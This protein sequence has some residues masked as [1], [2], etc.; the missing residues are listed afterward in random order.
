[1]VTMKTIRLSTC[2]DYG[3]ALRVT[4]ALLLLLWMLAVPR[5]TLQ[6]SNMAA[7]AEALTGMQRLD[8]DFFS[9]RAGLYTVTPD[10]YGASAAIWPTSLALDGAIN[11][12]R[13]IH[14]PADSARVR[15]I[16]GSLRQYLGPGGVYHARAVPSRRYTD[17]NNWIALDLL[18]AYSLLHDPSYLSEAEKIFQYLVASW[19]SRQGGIYWGDGQTQRPTVSTAPAITIGL[20]L[21]QI[22]HQGYYQTWA[23]RFYTWEN[24]HLR[25][26]NGHY[27]DHVNGDGTI[28]RTLRSYNQGVM[29]EANLAY[30]KL[31]GQARYLAQAQRIA[32]AA[33]VAFAGRWHQ[34]GDE[35]AFD[36]IYFQAIAQLKA[37]R[38]NG[39]SVAP[40]QDFVR[41]AWPAAQK[42]RVQHDQD[43][44][45]EQAAFVIAATA[46][47]A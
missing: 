36:A 45:L 29:I 32:R 23:A 8:G 3:V 10:K 44:L 6:A 21:A 2:S 46:L 17:D 41:W 38:S 20:E 47:S 26:P 12:A 35:A 19:D 40:I 28:D 39:I 1:Q 16:I 27:W 31:T 25:A 4:I 5:G 43:A 15:R 18:D 11:V 37:A 42:P 22:T 33:N 9:I 24:Q 7:R 14:A 34:R 30:A 13:Q